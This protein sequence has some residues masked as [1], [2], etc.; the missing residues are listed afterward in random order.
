MTETA[1]II[2]IAEAVKEA[3][4]AAPPGTFCLTFNAERGYVP[5]FELPDLKTLK[6]TVIHKALLE[7]PGEGSRGKTSR[8]YQIDIG[9]QKRCA[10]TVEFDTLTLLV[11]QIAGHLRAK[12]VAGAAWISTENDPVFIPEHVEQ[13]KQFTSVLT[14]TYRRVW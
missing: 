6:V 9:V 10:E 11:E 4:N 13:L 8:H 1:K 5:T 12:R 3:L 2:E 14:V 7:M